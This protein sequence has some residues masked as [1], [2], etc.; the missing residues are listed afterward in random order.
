MICTSAALQDGGDGCASWRSGAAL[1]AFVVRHGAGNA[2]INRCAH[3]PIELDWLPG[4]FFDA[5]RIF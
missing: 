1:P 3:V 2:Y 4:R 5:S